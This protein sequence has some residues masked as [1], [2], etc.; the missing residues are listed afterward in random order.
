MDGFP[1]STGSKILPGIISVLHQPSKITG[2]AYMESTE[3]SPKPRS[4][5]A[6]IQQLDARYGKTD[7]ERPCAWLQEFTGFALKP[8][9]NLKDF[10]AM[11][12]RVTTRMQTPNMPMSEE[13]LFSKALHALKLTETQL[14]IVLSALETEKNSRRVGCMNDITIRMF[15]PRRRAPDISEVFITQNPTQGTADTDEWTPREEEAPG[16]DIGE[17]ECVDDYFGGIFLAKPKRAQKNTKCAWR[18]SIR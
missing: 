13:M 2:L 6:L 5:Q 15:G 1:T 16:S 3:G 4:L 8:S 9:G 17:F 12:L 14:P 18:R 10:W 11:L 7:S